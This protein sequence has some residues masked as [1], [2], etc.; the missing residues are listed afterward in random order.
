MDRN[1]VTG[2]LLIF[3]ITIAWAW[4]TMPSEEELAQ[5]QAEQAAQDSI[6]AAQ[7]NQ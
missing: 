3:V 2:L 1:T 7:T 5:R 6:A 4:F